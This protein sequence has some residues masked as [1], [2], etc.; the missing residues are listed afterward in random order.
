MSLK[1]RLR[2]SFNDNVRKLK[3]F[4]FN[5]IGKQDQTFTKS[6]GYDLKNVYMYLFISNILE[7]T[8]GLGDSHTKEYP[9]EPKNSFCF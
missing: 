4:E 2:K 3:Y 8:V 7:I 9:F 6:I 1:T 5:L